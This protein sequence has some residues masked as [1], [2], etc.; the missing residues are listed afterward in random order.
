MH[1]GK[2]LVWTV[3]IFRNSFSL[4]F[5]ALVMYEIFYGTLFHSEKEPFLFLLRDQMPAD[6]SSSDPLA[7]SIT[8]PSA[9]HQRPERRAKLANL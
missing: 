4:Q 2:W 1:K 6:A 9:G 3:M 5:F 7:H 8:S